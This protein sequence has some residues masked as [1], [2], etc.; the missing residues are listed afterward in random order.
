M[1]KA[2]DKV[3]EFLYEALHLSD[4]ETRNQFNELLKNEDY[5]NT[6]RPKMGNFKGHLCEIAHHTV[7]FDELEAQGL[8]KDLRKHPYGQKSAPDHSFVF[9]GTEY[10][11]EDKN[12]SDLSYSKAEE[13]YV[14][15]RNYKH[16]YRTLSSD[17]KDLYY[18][19]EADIEGQPIILAVGLLP[20][21]NK[22][23]WRY[24]F[25]Y[26][27][28]R[29]SKYPDKVASNLNRIPI[30]VSTQEAVDSIWSDNVVGLIRK[31]G[32]K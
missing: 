24:C 14:D 28:P 31:R 7:K 20:Q 30:D 26:D 12:C 2:R 4:P 6:L 11:V 15:V 9:E 3:E 8:I 10:W 16:S 13:G 19:P 22:F 29:H 1:L 21:T 5:Y 17:H 27:L 32:L 18:D 23:E 25:F